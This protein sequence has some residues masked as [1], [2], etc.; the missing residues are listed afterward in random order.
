MHVAGKGAEWIRLVG[1]SATGGIAGLIQQVERDSALQCLTI[2]KA[3]I[4]GGD[5]DASTASDV[6]QWGIASLFDEDVAGGEQDADAV[7]TGVGAQTT[8]V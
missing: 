8:P 7:A 6:V 4:Q 2:G 1:F 5:A 3:S